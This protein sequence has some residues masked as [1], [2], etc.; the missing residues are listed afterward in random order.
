MLL[1]LPI[2]KL[3]QTYGMNLPDP[4]RKITTPDWVDDDL[5]IFMFLRTVA[6]TRLGLG[7]VDVDY[8]DYVYM[9]SMMRIFKQTFLERKLDY[10]I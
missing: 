1:N 3:F 4:W 9:P 7:T 8:F 5:I 6:I 2:V 10:T